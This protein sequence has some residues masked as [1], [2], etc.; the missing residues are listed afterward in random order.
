MIRFRYEPFGGIISA[1]RPA[2]LAH[3]GRPLAW[4]LGGGRSPLWQTDQA[5]L[6]APTEVHLA[7]T[8]RCTRQCPHCYVNASPDPKGQ[9]EMDLAAMRKTLEG[10]A[11]MGVFHLALGGGEALLREDLFAIA[12]YARELRMV[13]NLTTSGSGMTREVARRCRV[14]GQINVSLDRDEPQPGDPREAK[15]HQEALQAIDLLRK[16][17]I[18]PGINCVLT[19]NN[20][21]GLDR[22]FALA[23]NKRLSEIECLRFKPSGRAREL[24]H[25]LACTPEQ[26]REL[27]PL[28]RSLGKRHRVNLKVDCSLLPMVCYHETS[29]DQLAQRSYGC[30]A[31]NVLAGMGP[32]GRIHPCSFA[33][34]LTGPER[35]L[36]ACW[37]THPD[38]E[39]YRNW[40]EQAPEPC[41]TCQFLSVC[42]G[43][44]HV[45][46]EFE[47]GDFQAPDPGCPFVVEHGH[48]HAE[49]QRSTHSAS[50]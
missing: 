3:V 39:R 47:T 4:L 6:T 13:P 25:E 23:R 8:H 21:D 37:Q 50:M 44:C 18:R 42:K 33:P 12:K 28:L 7:S 27:I 9:A 49:D 24:Y 5:H 34:P 31:G 17:G 36:Q 35:D 45:V 19:R 10:L 41:R 30:E 1:T 32:D 48:R 15:A 46:A 22:L 20:L 16:E 11:A 29:P 26:N 43:G 2:F 38:L 40:T 14:F